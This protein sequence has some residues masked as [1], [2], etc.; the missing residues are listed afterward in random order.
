MPAAMPT[1]LPG[2][3]HLH[4]ALPPTL[5][6]R[7]CWWGR[8]VKVRHRILCLAPVFGRPFP[9]SMI[10]LCVSL[11]VF[12]G[13][14]LPPSSDYWHTCSY[15]RRRI[16]TA[17]TDS[18]RISI[19]H[20]PAHYRCARNYTPATRYFLGLP[21]ATARWHAIAYHALGASWDFNITVARNARDICAHAS[22]PATWWTTVILCILLPSSCPYLPCWCVT[23]R[24][25][26]A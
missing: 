18:A 7:A 13:R 19:C 26:A 21:L 8:W 11:S 12:A 6:A 1:F 20:F 22:F 5:H 25:Y 24:T 2:Y 9:P 16:P 3:Y 17:Y 23:V 10:L 14:T 15:S 4:S